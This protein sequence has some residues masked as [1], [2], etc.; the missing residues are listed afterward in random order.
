LQIKLKAMQLWIS[1]LEEQ[2]TL[3]LQTMVQLE[4]EA[5]DR[6]LL[7]QE[8]LNRSSQAAV[9]YRTKLDDYDKDDFL[10]KVCAAVY[11][12]LFCSQRVGT[13]RRFGL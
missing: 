9:A 6:V 3:F 10:E 5:G 1:D 11:G 2:Q 4:Q 8:G 12:F 13:L 7:L